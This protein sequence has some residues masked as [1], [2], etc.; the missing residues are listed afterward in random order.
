MTR[1]TSPLLRRLCLV[2]GAAVVAH[3]FTAL[4]GSGSATPSA[5]LTSA[6]FYQL[7]LRNG[8]WVEGRLAGIDGDRVQIST[9]EGGTRA[10]SRDE[11][12]AGLAGGPQRR[13][14]VFMT[15]L[16]AG[17]LVFNDG[18]L[19]PGTYRA[20]GA[21]A[22][23]EHRWIGAIPIQADLVSELRFVASRR[24]PT[25]QD[26][27]TVL[28]MNGDISQ[29]FVD[30]LGDTVAFTPLAQPAP[31]KNARRED[32]N[33]HE[34][35]ADAAADQRRIQ[36]DRIA[37]ISFAAASASP[38]KGSM[39]WTDD[40]TIVRIASI[41][42]QP[43]PEPAWRLTL[44]DPAL[45]AGTGSASVREGLVRPVAILF[46]RDI[47]SPLASC[48]PPKSLPPQLSYRYESAPEIRM[49]PSDQSLLGLGSIELSGPVTA[50]FQLPDRM[51]AGPAGCVFTADVAL[52]EPVPIDSRTVI[53][54][55]LGAVDSG[56]V[57]LDATKPRASVRLE[58]AT[59]R[60]SSLVIEIDDGGDGIPGDR[61]LIERGCFIGQ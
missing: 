31:A 32:A 56:Q 39:V 23:W 34:R 7:L 22:R 30:A 16:A 26:G 14:T 37:A 35:T 13:S 36:P 18:Q 49:E 40:G 5:S 58:V 45:I 2:A 50:T 8:T 1:S 41:G 4:A 44:A 3:S 52:V 20:D 15:Q 48:D 38:V 54:I 33:A 6:P 47:L 19:L 42:F 25:R 10:I 43:S 29:G 61:V 55:R 59:A 17:T 28:F 57:V 60:D 53:R 21:A 12:V 9:A 51:R 46:N 11:L 27:D 24:A